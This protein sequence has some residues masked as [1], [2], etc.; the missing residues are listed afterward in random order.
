MQ[1]GSL[2]SLLLC[3]RHLGLGSRCLHLHASFVFLQ[4]LGQFRMGFTRQRQCGQLVFLLRQYR[5]DHTVNQQIRVAS[6]RTGE[7]RVSL[8]RQTKVPT[9]H[10]RVNGLL[11]GAQQHGVYLLRIRTVFSGLC[12]FLKFSRLRV[13]TQSKRQSQGFEVVSKNVFFLGCRA[14][15]HTEQSRVLALF[16]KVST[17]DIGGQHGLFNQTVR[18]VAR[19]RYDLF[20]L[21]TFI[22]HNLRFGGFK[23]NRTPHCTRSQ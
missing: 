20:N 7:V 22:A 23:I 5:F 14:F 15:M 1:A 10:R 11:H 17:A 19:T 13:I 2:P 6:N 3:I 9:V 4:S 12:N 21:T 16:N 18:F 8:I